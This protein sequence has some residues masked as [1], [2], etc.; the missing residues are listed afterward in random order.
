MGSVGDC[1]DSALCESVFA[2][3]EGELLDRR[4]FSTRAEAKMTFFDFSEGWYNPQPRHSSLGCLSR[5]AFERS[6]EAA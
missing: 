6:R 3:F 1:Y 5:A 4:S 2:K